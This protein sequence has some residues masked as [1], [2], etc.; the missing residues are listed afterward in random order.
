MNL[1]DPWD[2]ESSTPNAVT[3]PLLEVDIEGPC[4]THARN[5]GDYVRKFKSPANRSAPDDLFITNGWVWFVEFKRPG[6][7]LTDKQEDEHDRIKLAGG[8]VYMYDNVDAFKKK[9][10]EIAQ[11]PPRC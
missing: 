8:E 4:K 1:Q 3:R 10:R 2:L 5:Q 9:R 11:R 7:T 6:G